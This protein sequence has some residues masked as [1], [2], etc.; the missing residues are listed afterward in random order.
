MSKMG[1]QAYYIEEMQNQAA[2]IGHR[3]RY[4]T[5]RIVEIRAGRHDSELDGCIICDVDGEER[6]FKWIWGFAT[7]VSN[8]PYHGMQITNARRVGDPESINGLR[9]RYIV[10]TLQDDEMD[11][12]RPFLTHKQWGQCVPLKTK[13]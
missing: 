11:R 13:A 5:A 12:A 8:A 9:F 10:G 4:E 3:E 1:H 2:G 6:I 7:F